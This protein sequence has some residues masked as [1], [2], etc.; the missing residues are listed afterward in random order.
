MEDLFYV[1]TMKTRT[2]KTL[3]LAS[4]Y[5]DSCK[6]IFDKDEAIWFETYSEAKDFCEKYFKDFRDYI[7]EEV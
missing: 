7:I 5:G 2:D 3:Y 6:W 1:V 4:D